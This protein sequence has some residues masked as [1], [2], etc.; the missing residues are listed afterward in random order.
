MEIIKSMSL[1]DKISGVFNGCNSIRQNEHL[2]PLNADQ[3]ERRQVVSSQ[4][5]IRDVD[6]QVGRNLL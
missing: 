4:I 3:D 6:Q 1:L 2:M 5:V